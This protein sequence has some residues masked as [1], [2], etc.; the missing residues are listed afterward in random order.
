MD[1]KRN[2]TKIKKL[3][4]V[5]FLLNT[6]L[7]ISCTSNNLI[8]E[9]TKIENKKTETS[10][11]KEQKEY[12]KLLLRFGFNDNPQPSDLFA[13]DKF[14]NIEKE[15]NSY[16]NQNYEYIELKSQP[17]YYIGNYTGSEN[18][19][20]SKDT[21][22]QQI[23]MEEK[24]FNATDLKTIEIGEKLSKN[25]S[26]KIVNGRAFESKD[27][28]ISQENQEVNIILG[29][30]YINQYKIGDI[31][32]LELHK[33]NIEFKVIGFLEKGLKLNID[34]GDLILDNYIVVP[35]YNIEYSPNS[36]EEETYQ[37]LWYSQKNEGLIKSSEKETII[38]LKKDINNINKKYDLFYEI[39]DTPIKIYLKGK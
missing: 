23:N 36:K 1:G 22:N 16:L 3:I 27:F 39:Q 34:N 4:L 33:K 5:I 29:N 10:N 19:A 38:K 12:Y 14:L 2:I 31:L 15:I 24:S 18:F 13:R 35:F 21:I 25:F 20:I 7:L 8:N 30:S 37:Q 11:M 17:L 26:S 28:I 6:I 32:E 9:D